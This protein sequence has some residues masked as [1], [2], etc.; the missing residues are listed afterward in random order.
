MAIWY[1]TAKKATWSWAINLSTTVKDKF[2]LNSVT[3]HFDSVPTTVENLI[4]KLDGKDW[5]SYDTILY[6]IDPSEAIATDI[7]FL[8]DRDLFFE[9]WDIINATYPNSDWNTYWIR[10]V[11]QWL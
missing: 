6:K 11:T 4:I 3:V 9:A 1:L 8:P 10:I 5:D 7:V 2:Q